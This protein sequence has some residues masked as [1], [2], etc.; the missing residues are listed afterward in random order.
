MVVGEAP[1]QEEEA[2]RRPF[3]GQSGELLS[4]YLERAG[5]GRDE[6]Y[7]TNLCKH[8]PKGNK[9]S[10]ALGSDELLEDLNELHAEIDAVDP[11]I[12]IALGG[13][14]TQYLA[15]PAGMKN[16]AGIMKWR[17]SFLPTT[18]RWGKE[19]K[20]LASYHPA[21]VLRAWDQNP[22]F[23]HDLRKAVRD[24]STPK[25]DLPKYESVI[26]PDPEQLRELLEEA[27]S[28]PYI[29]TDIETFPG[30]TFSCIGF[31]WSSDVG[32]CITKDRPDLHHFLRE[33]WES[34]TCKI[35]QYGTYDISFMRFFYGWKIGGYYAGQGWDTYVA[36]AH[37]LPSF[38]RNL[39]F[40]CSIYTRFPFYKEERK[41]W[42]EEGV[43]SSLWEYNIKDVIGTYEVAM[44]QMLE[45]T[46]LYPGG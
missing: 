16:G 33:M 35:L 14:P 8:R 34:D 20:V 27:L 39:G 38:K 18:P 40:L 32:V 42:K 36:S 2:Q 23:F 26:D 43:M 46:E 21:Y 15:A 25:L 4:R 12:I 28:A 17:G 3:V 7:L 45:M 6:V 24:A 10:Q 37:L 13:W 41:V 9:F 19:R 22:I 44:A 29:S 31:C 5:V 11:N 30:G 1:G